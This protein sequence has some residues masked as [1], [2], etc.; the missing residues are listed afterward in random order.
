MTWN[1]RIID[2][3]THKALHE[4]YYDDKGVPNGWTEKPADFVCDA[5]E[6]PEE[7]AGALAMALSDAQRRPMLRHVDGKLVPVIEATD[8][9]SEN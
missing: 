2:F 5:D 8:A 1:Y 6:G 3:G 4:V 9:G 7:I